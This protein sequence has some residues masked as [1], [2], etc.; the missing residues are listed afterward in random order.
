MLSTLAAIGFDP[1]IRGILVVATGAI[2]LLGSIWMILSTNSGV[3][4]G[5]LLAL[6]AFFGWMIIMGAFW[7]IRGIGF[8]GESVSWRILDFNRGDINQSSVEPARDLPDPTLLQGVGYQ[9]AVDNVDLTIGVG[10]DQTTP[11]LEFADEL[12]RDAVDYEDLTDEEFAEQVE[13][14]RLRDESV[15]L[16]QVFSVAPDFI[17]D[18]EGTA[19]PDLNGWKILSTADAGEVQSTAG[20]AILEEN[21]FDF[22]SQSEF[23]FLDAFTIGGKPKL[24]RD[25][26]DCFFC[27]DRFDRTWLWIRNAATIKNPPEYAVVQLQAVDEEALIIEEGKA[28]RFPVVDEEAQIISVVLIRDLGN[29]RFPPAMVTM[30]SLLIFTA[31]AWLLHVRDLEAMARVKEFEEEG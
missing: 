18:Q 2:V 14:N 7:W 30:G 17:E 3:R 28:P 20:S 15:T 25:I 21:G 13:R 10:E 5:S 6:S 16:S 1:E 11:L 4:L 23:K 26:T 27:K 24:A 12:D 22:E 31:L 19:F 29:L 9:L 8:V